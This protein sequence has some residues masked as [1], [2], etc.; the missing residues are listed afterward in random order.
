MIGEKDGVARAD[1]TGYQIKPFFVKIVILFGSENK[2]FFDF[3]SKS[4]FVI[5]DD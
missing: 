5:A 3:I 1:R 2:K 4:S